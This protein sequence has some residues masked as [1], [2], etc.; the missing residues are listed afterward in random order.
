MDK[1]TA[2]Q[3][4]SA[5]EGLKSGDI[6][7]ILHQFSQPLTAI[8]NYAQTGSCMLDDGLVDPQRLKE[9]FNRISAQSARCVQLSQALRACIDDNSSGS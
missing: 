1:D 2:P 5:A 4:R 6:A 3:V 7:E 9:L 8:D